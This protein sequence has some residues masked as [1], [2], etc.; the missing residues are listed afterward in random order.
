MHVFGELNA[1]A[2]REFLEEF[3]KGEPGNGLKSCIILFGVMSG[4][5]MR[6]AD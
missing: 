3:A 6:S 5:F 2:N 4:G 1:L